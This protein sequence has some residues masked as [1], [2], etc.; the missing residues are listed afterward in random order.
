MVGSL[1]HRVWGQIRAA[2]IIVSLMMLMAFAGIGPVGTASVLADEDTTPP[3]FQSLSVSPGS[4]A[5]GGT[6]TFTARITDDDS[7]VSGTPYIL[8]TGPGW[9]GGNNAPAPS[10]RAD[11]KSAATSTG[12]SLYGLFQL[13]AGTPQDGIYT[14]NVTVPP[15]YAI[16]TYTVRFL[17][18]RDAAGNFGLIR[19]PNPPAGG[20]SFTVT[21]GITDTTPPVF[22]S[23]SVS[24]GSVAAGDTVTFTAHITDDNSGVAGTPYIAVARTGA[25]PTSKSAGADELHGAFQ[26]TAGTAQDGTYTANI[27]IPATAGSGTYSVQYLVAQDAAGNFTLLQAPTPPIGGVTFTIA[28][29]PPNAPTNLHVSGATTSSISFAWTPPDATSGIMASNGVQANDLGVAAT[30][31]TL[32]GL[33]PG[34]WACVS[35]AAYN[36]SGASAWTAW[37]CGEAGTA[38]PAKPTNLHVSGATSTSVSFAWTPPDAT[39]GIVASNGVQ[40]NDLGVA[41][42]SYTLSGLTP[43]AWTCLSVA[44]YN[45]SGPS[46][47]TAWSCGQAGAG[48][49]PA[50]PTNVHV[51]GT[52]A[53]SVTFTWTPPDATSNIAV[54]NGVHVTDLST[55]ASTYTQTG[56]ASGAWS[57]LSVAAY[58]TAGASTWTTWVCGQAVGIGGAKTQPPTSKPATGKAVAK[59]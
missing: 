4:I 29:T 30:S 17:A 15:Q 40:A 39:S 3:V 13:T 55:A 41:A 54:S 44:A 8:V 5:A 56:L 10:S 33:A 53:S 32:T 2:G 35:V 16:G 49:A 9:T 51:T 48:S 37:V 38:P 6:V 11:A 52:T 50:M 27:A 58:N 22:Q 57:C 28:G 36:S 23:L 24:P 1:G 45:A 25:A 46:P 26:R 12:A 59:P 14:A 20:V 34:T 42:S 18:A 31:Y 47:W 19:S 43:G 7:G 21:N